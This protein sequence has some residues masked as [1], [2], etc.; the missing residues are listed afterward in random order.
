MIR[1]DLSW[2]TSRP[3]AH[4]GFHNL[5]KGIPENTLR[6]AEEAVKKSLPIECDVQL[7]SD[8]EAVV[9]HDDELDRL[10]GVAGRVAD[11]SL[12]EMRR[13]RIGG[14]DSAPP[15]LA[16]LLD[17]IAGRVPLLIELKSHG[18]PGA[19]EDVVLRDLRAYA[20]AAAVL[21]F[22]P[23]SVRWFRRH[24]PDIVRGQ[25]AGSYHRRGGG[26]GPLGRF[27]RRHLLTLATSRPHFVA[28]ELT[29]LDLPSSRLWRRFGGPLLAWTARSADE[30][31]AALHLADNVIFEGFGPPAG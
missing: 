23:R 29:C 19:L 28:H 5:A 11:Q 30:F 2:L 25:I 7:T 17:F 31:E 9:F 26:I 27:A 10:A 22:S 3:I 18:R 15:S 6:A 16:E 1:P 13:L 14:T 12:R 4:R 21:S 20:G 24:A 8:G